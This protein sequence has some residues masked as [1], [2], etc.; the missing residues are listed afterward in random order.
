M[1]NKPIISIVCALAKDNL[2]IGFR[3]QLPWHLPPDMEY[4]KTLTYGHTVI[5]G[6]K[7]YLAIGKPLSGRVNIVLSDNEMQIPG[8]AICRN[9]KKAFAVA[10]EKEDREI[11][12]IGGG[13]VFLQA[14]NFADKLYLIEHK[15]FHLKC[16]QKYCKFHSFFLSY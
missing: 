3:G 9:L 15:D 6:R 16:L 7:T 10:K 14:I 2:G 1:E 13:N 12:V 8:C 11:F 4:F 5:M